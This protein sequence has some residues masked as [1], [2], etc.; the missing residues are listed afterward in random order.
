MR[1][2]LAAVLLPVLVVALVGPYTFLPSM[3]EYAVAHDVQSRLGL[4]K[5][6]EVKLESDPPLDMLAGKISGGSIALKDAGLGGVRTE[7]AS[8]D[9]DPFDM[10]VWRSIR[11]GSV[12]AREPLSGRLRV[13]VSEAEVSRLAKANADMPVRCVDIK[14]DGMVV[15][16]EATAFGASFPASVTGTLGVRDG[17]LVFEPRS[18][19]AAG[20]PVPKG[21]ADQLLAGTRFDY[22]LKGL[23]YK[24]EITGVD[25]AE[26]RIV[27]TGGVPKIPLGVYP[28]G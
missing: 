8:I 10:N 25:T 19:D 18:L 22:P 9:L 27:L 26:G 13:E 14:D 15:G 11:K 17:D 12:V 28:G 3:L 4:D 5:T 16:S 2:I 24:S 21:L 1:S 23:P 7:S 20:F 6:P